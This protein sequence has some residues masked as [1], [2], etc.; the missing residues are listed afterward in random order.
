MKIEYVKK[1]LFDMPHGY[2]FVHCISADFALGAGIAKTFDEKYN[3]RDR[4]FKMLDVSLE[5]IVEV[6][7]VIKV[8]NVYNLVTKKRCFE[9]P[10]YEDFREAIETLV[11]SVVEEGITKIAMPKIGAGLDKL[12]W[13][14]VNAIIKNAF[15]DVNV[16]ITVCFLED[17][18]DFPNNEDEEAENDEVED[19]Y[20]YGM[21]T[22]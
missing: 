11:E 3:M 22:Y 4:L 1:D 2:C 20:P 14:I 7:D 16:D 9:K 5:D 12:D 17:D 13:K 10:T 8:D 21:F 18:L 15:E 19:D 6:G